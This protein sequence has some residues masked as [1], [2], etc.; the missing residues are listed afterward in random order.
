[1]FR[2]LKVEF[3]KARG[4]MLALCGIT[5]ALEI[6]FL[7]AL[8]GEWEEHLAIAAFLL[9]I[10]GFAAAMFVFIRGITSYS[11]ELNSTSGYLL[12]M[13]P[14]SSLKIMGSKYLYTFLNGVVFMVLLGG[15]AFLDFE[16]LMAHY[17]ETGNTI[18]GLMAMLRMQGVYIDQFLYAALCI[19]VY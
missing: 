4:A 7:A 18:K 9:V 11:R 6:Y 12:F 16:L 10:S 17:V 5:I 2:L 19:I 8:H 13:T 1:M 3:R 14:N 15:L